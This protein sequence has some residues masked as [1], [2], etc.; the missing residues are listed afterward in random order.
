[1]IE[2]KKQLIDEN[3]KV[4]TYMVVFKKS[5]ETFRRYVASNIYYVENYDYKNKIDEKDK[6]I[7]KEIVKKYIDYNS[8]ELAQNIINGE[9]VKKFEKYKELNFDKIKHIYL[10]TKKLY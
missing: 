8:W 3:F 5:Y 2:Y 6:T 9:I 10:D 1:M 4:L 7:I